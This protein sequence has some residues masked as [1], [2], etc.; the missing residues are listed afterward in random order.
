MAENE[1]QH[2]ILTWLS[3]LDFGTRLSEMLN[4]I[5]EGTGTWLLESQEF[6]AWLKGDIREIWCPGMRESSEGEYLGHT[7]NC[8]VAGAGKT[9]LA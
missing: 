1:K 4:R 8:D 2:R 9:I 7:T 6:T 3:S 5:Q